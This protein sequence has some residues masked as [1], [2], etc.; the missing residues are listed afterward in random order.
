MC[1]CVCIQYRMRLALWERVE[2]R[3][4]E[5]LGLCLSIHLGTLG[6]LYCVPLVEIWCKEGDLGLSNTQLAILSRSL[7]A[8][9]GKI[10]GGGEEEEEND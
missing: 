8:L 4:E 6:T 3:V 1:V 9:L 5:A 10:V 2:G 7:C